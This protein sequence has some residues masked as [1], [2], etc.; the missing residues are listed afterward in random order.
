MSDGY[1]YRMKIRFGLGIFILLFGVLSCSKGTEKQLIG[2]WKLIDIDYS[3]HLKEVQP[4]L[5]EEFLAMTD[6]HKKNVLNLI[7]FDFKSE[8]KCNI[9]SPKFGGGTANLPGTWH[10]NEAED[11]LF[12][13]NQDSES[14]ALSFTNDAKLKL[15]SHQK[16]LRVYT[17][18]KE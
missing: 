6:N 10:L 14:F 18:V 7:F 15:E 17:F 13:E 16:P 2:N 1:F 8:G 4:E 11:S 12:I 5:R 9:V 3:K